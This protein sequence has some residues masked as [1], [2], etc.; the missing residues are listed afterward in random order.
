MSGIS[1]SRSSSHT[2]PLL[3]LFAAPSHIGNTFLML[4]L[5]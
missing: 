4:E 1:P 2:C 5:L 3:L